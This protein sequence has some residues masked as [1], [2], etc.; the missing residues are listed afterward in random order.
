MSAAGLRLID[1]VPSHLRAKDSVL[2]GEPL[3]AFL[4]VLGDPLRE[5]RAAIEQL[6]DD[7]FVERAAPDVLPFLATLFGAKLL[8]TD[9]GTNRAVV[10]KAIAWRRR[11]GT[12]VALEELLSATSR[13][14][15]EVD[16]G[17]RSLLVT[18]DLNAAGVSRSMLT[19]LWDPIVL[20]DPLS[21][22]PPRGD[23]RRA[24]PLVREG[25]ARFPGETLDDARRR[26]GRADAG[27]VA[28]SPRTVDLRGWARPEGVLVR[29]S[30][31]VVVELEGVRPGPVDTR[32][33]G[34]RVFALDPLGRAGPLVWQEP[35]EEA[36]LIPELTSR[37]EPESQ[38]PTLR[39][40]AALLT[41]TALAAEP[42]LVEAS[43]AVVITVEG[44]PVIGPRLL[45]PPPTPLP[46][47]PVGPAA[48]LRFAD[49]SRPG[50]DQIWTLEVFA[51]RPELRDRLLS[52]DLT[53]SPSPLPAPSV[54]DGARLERDGATLSLKVTRQVGLAS[55]RTL[56][57][58]T[59][60]WAP[61]LLD[62]LGTP[63]S[64]A[65][66]VTI[67]GVR[68]VVRAESSPGTGTSRVVLFDVEAGM[69]WQP[70]TLNGAELPDVM[71][72]AAAALPAESR[73]YL[74][75]V[76]SEDGLGVWRVTFTDLGSAV[77]ERLDD[78]DATVRPSRRFAPAAGVR[79]GRFY[80]Y[81]GLAGERSL[82]DLWSLPLDE[83]GETALF[84]FHFVRRAEPRCEAELVPALGGFVLLGGQTQRGALAGSVLYCDLERARPTWRALA[85]LPIEPEAPGLLVARALGSDGGGGLEV[86]LWADDTRPRRL[87]LPNQDSSWSNGPLEDG[88]PNPPA[89][90]EVLSLESGDVLSLGSSPLPPSEVIVRL[91]ARSHLVFLPALDLPPGTSVRF[92]VFRDGSTK[93]DRDPGELPEE[94]ERGP[95]EPSAERVADTPRIGVP[96]RLRRHFYELRQRILGA[97]QDPALLPD[98]DD[99]V[100]LDPRSSRVILPRSVPAGALLVS[101]RVG[102]GSA[103]GAGCLPRLRRPLPFWEEPD[104]PKRVPPDLPTL[105][106]HRASTSVSAWVSPERAGETLGALSV[107]GSAAE[108]LAGTAAD[109]HPVLGIL[110][111]AAL[112]S[113]RLAAPGRHGFSL[114]ANDFGSTPMI[115][116]DSADSDSPALSITAEIA[117]GPTAPV[118]AGVWLAGLWVAGRTEVAMASG[119]IDLRW[120]TLG[121]PG[122]VSLSIAGGQHQA[123]LGR[124]SLHEV[125]LEVRL[126]GCVLGVVE[127]PPWVRLIADGCTFD[128]G[129]ATA[130]AIRA[131]GAEVR[132]RHCTVRGGVDAGELRASSC[133]F[134][135]P[136]RVD[137]TDLGWI[138][139]SLLR[140]GEGK[141]ALYHALDHAISFAS[142]RATDPNY[143]VLAENNGAGA[144]TRGEHGRLPGAH[145]DRSDRQRELSLRT[146]E[147]LPIGLSVTDLDRVPFD[148]ARM[149]RRTS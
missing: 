107:V 6:L 53:A 14:P 28:T 49:P 82:G 24:S 99:V 51:K 124:R 78:P 33:D 45:S 5:L 95:Y 29:S 138:R 43:G 120:C 115:F 35:L 106:G 22:R 48:L 32:S 73:L 127:V 40:A 128:A 139:H 136:V 1:L 50:T 89:Y 96:R 102:R 112:S 38:G 134:G 108:A 25:V 27:R 103:L 37:H 79:D 97:P 105:P 8:G 104:L 140:F 130:S 41:P 44:V 67:G 2:P 71:G 143:L 60:S 47:V 59:P 121:G 52:V 93:R 117:S 129:S 81:G 100:G 148:L 135:G 12:L 21:R 54:E 141:P 114:V 39:R 109:E 4:E 123:L 57:G 11:R 30:R 101:Y 110:A 146:A 147:N 91:G 36:A 98:A 55:R 19:P 46:V 137:R 118:Y 7:H 145:A 94:Y 68:C 80:L 84:Q 3:R 20:V 111:S 113:T 133:A 142:V 88:A 131:L 92:D 125:E 66:E 69:A 75:G 17:F 144:L 10:A 15:V 31:L 126:Y 87:T 132:L 63:R 122:E 149:G 72:F 42:E 90:G 116:A 76:A 26:L 119:Q 23:S 64:P 13:W 83:G 86:L 65:R 85:D 58:T 9:P 34:R 16:E 77:V 61:F 74:A 56:S 18:E 62:P 70:L